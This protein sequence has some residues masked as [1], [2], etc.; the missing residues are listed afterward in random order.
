MNYLK[1]V[2]C[3]V[4]IVFLAT[5]AIGEDL[6]D[7][8]E[9]DSGTQNKLIKNQI[10]QSTQAPSNEIQTHVTS[11]TSITPSTGI[12]RSANL[13]ADAWTWSD[14]SGF[15]ASAVDNMMTRKGVEI[16][17][18]KGVVVTWNN[19]VS[20]KLAQKFHAPGVDVK[21]AENVYYDPSKKILSFSK[22]EQ[23]TSYYP[24]SD[25][26]HIIDGSFG[27]DEK[28][29]LRNFSGK[30]VNEENWRFQNPMEYRLKYT[31][32]NPTTGETVVIDNPDADSNG[33]GL[34]DLADAARGGNMRYLD[35]DDDGLPNYD[36]VTKYNT[37]LAKKST[38]EGYTDSDY[39]KAF[40]SAV[41]DGKPVYYNNKDI[42]K[43]LKLPSNNAFIDSDADGLSDVVEYIKGTNSNKY[44]TDEDGLGDGYEI[45]HGLA[46]LE[47]DDFKIMFPDNC[48]QCM[49]EMRGWQGSD[50]MAELGDNQ[51]YFES[52]DS[53]IVLG[54]PDGKA[55]YFES[56][57]PAKETQVQTTGANSMVAS[58]GMISSPNNDG[59]ASITISK[60]G[61]KQEKHSQMHAPGI[62]Y[63][64]PIILKTNLDSITPYTAGKEYPVQ[65][66]FD[67]NK[68]GI[69][70]D[71]VIAEFDEA[72]NTP[73]NRIGF[74]SAWSNWDVTPSTTTYI[75]NRNLTMPRVEKER[76]YPVI[77][78]LDCSRDNQKTLRAQLNTSIKVVPSPK[79][80][81]TPQEKPKKTEPIIEDVTEQELTSSR[82]QKVTKHKEAPAEIKTAKQSTKKQ[83]TNQAIKQKTAQ[84]KKPWWKFW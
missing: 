68:Q 42:T 52:F 59:I 75:Y 7:I 64:S 9:G 20:A 49:L 22:A 50:V 74:P 12:I 83:G 51:L 5:S 38:N 82:A 48:A 60:P 67:T 27:F 39:V 72:Y 24:R 17:N 77:I 8:Q 47:K 3:W 56:D 81:Y 18:A 13:P 30:F 4:I 2:L 44:D 58:G 71:H 29:Q 6:E 32:V 41:A 62:K 73:E 61:M 37:N 79:E 33:D 46:P 36:E 76:T 70:C 54:Q 11:P 25:I 40:N 57:S 69:T 26:P 23:A 28:F 1:I 53:D 80:T 16:Q 43:E 55:T 63:E 65:I 34:S 10:L 15:H 21:N 19:D 14:A 84:K 31:V 45:S 35:F 66:L 78:N